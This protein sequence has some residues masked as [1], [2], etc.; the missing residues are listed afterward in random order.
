[1]I[2]L[3]SLIAIARCAR[4]RPPAPPPHGFGERDGDGHDGEDAGE[5][6]IERE[7][8][9][10]AGDRIADALRS[11]EELADQDSDQ[12]AADGSARAGDDVGQDARQDELEVEVLLAAAQRANDVDEQRVD[13]SHAGTG[14]EHEW[15]NG[16]REDDDRLAGHADAKEHDHERRER[17]QRARIEDGHQR[18]ERVADPRPPAHDHADHDADDRRGTKAVAERRRADTQV[19]EQL[20]ALDEI[21]QRLG[22]QTGLADEQRIERHDEKDRLPGGEEQCDREAAKQD[23]AVALGKARP[24]RRVCGL[25]VGALDGPN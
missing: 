9:A 15:E 11:G 12:R 7:Q 19:I 17:D 4:E 21:E 22:D 18:V 6:A 24:H 23:V 2:A 1:M 3:I 25:N 13:R 8:V 10:E 14:V 16:K 20:P 5:H